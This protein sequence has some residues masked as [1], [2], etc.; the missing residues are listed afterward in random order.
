MWLKEGSACTGH[1][2]LPTSFANVRPANEGLAAVSQTPKN[3][4]PRLLP[5]RHLSL[6]LPLAG[7]K[8]DFAAFTGQSSSATCHGL[9]SGPG[10]EDGSLVGLSFS[11]VLKLGKP[12]LWEEELG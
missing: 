3:Q 1:W 4:N 10:L 8:L 6:A 7:D 2:G 5:G 11:C 12:L 9:A